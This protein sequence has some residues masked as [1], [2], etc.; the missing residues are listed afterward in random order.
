MAPTRASS[1]HLGQELN[2]PA[3]GL[4]VLPCLPSASCKAR[5]MMDHPGGGCPGRRLWFVTL[6]LAAPVDNG[7]ETPGGRGAGWAALAAAPGT[8]HR[9]PGHQGGTAATG[10]LIFS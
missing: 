10:D 2:E 6:I 1:Y 3:S 5:E 7:L 4:F 8:L 9:A